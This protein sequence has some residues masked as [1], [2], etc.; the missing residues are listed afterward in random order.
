MKTKLRF[1]LLRFNF[2]NLKKKRKEK[3]ENLTGKVTHRGRLPG[4]SD[5]DATV[6]RHQILLCKR[7]RP[8]GG[9]GGG[10]GTFGAPLAKR[11]HNFKT[12]Q[13]MTTKLSDFS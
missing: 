4:L 10:E 9:G 3:T 12:F 13:A 11:M 8:G 5:L 2:K 1:G 6:S 7:L